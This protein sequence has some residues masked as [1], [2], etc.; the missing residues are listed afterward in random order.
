MSVKER[1]QFFKKHEKDCEEAVQSYV[2]IN[3]SNIMIFDVASKQDRAI[4]EKD[5]MNHESNLT[6]RSMWRYG[7][8]CKYISERS[9]NKSKRIKQVSWQNKAESC[10]I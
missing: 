3:A 2:G 10:G 8:S 7:N 4:I 1:E 6:A 5:S 9:E